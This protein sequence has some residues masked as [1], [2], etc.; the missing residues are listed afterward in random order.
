M[1]LTINAPVVEGKLR[2]EAAKRGV[3]AEK[4][5]ETILASH[6]TS[7]TPKHAA[8]PFYATATPDEW[9]KEFDTWVDSHSVK[10]PHPDHAFS[11][12]SFYEG[13]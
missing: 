4:Y 11:R 8:P 5:A 7:E 12:E 1:S 2:R 10:E 3:S 13:R 6:L 9:I